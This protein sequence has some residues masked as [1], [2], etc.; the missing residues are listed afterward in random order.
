MLTNRQREIALILLS[1]E[2]NLF[3][4]EIAERFSVSLRTIK[5]DMQE[6]KKWFLKNKVDIKSKPN[7]GIVISKLDEKKKIEIY[8][9]LLSLSVDEEI[10]SIEARIRRIILML[11]LH[12]SKYMTAEFLANQLLVSEQ[13]IYKDMK[14]VKEY[15]KN[16]NIIFLSLPRKGY[17]ISGDEV[18]IRQYAEYLLTNKKIMEDSY[19]VDVYLKYKEELSSLSLD[20]EKTVQLVHQ[21]LQKTISQSLINYKPTSVELFTL[22]I[23]LVISIC[24]VLKGK[25]IQLES[26][27]NEFNASLTNFA[28]FTYFVA[29]RTFEQSDLQ[30]TKDEFIYIYRNA[31]LNNQ[32]EN[33]LEITNNI[34]HYVSEK[35]SVPFYN[36]STLKTNLYSHF[37]D[38][39]A[40]ENAILLENN[41]FM[42]DI[43]SQYNYLYYPVK[44]AC[45][46]YI[47][48]PNLSVKMIS[49]FVTLH[50]LVSLETTFSNNK[51]LKA[52]YVCASG[53]GVARVIK[54][55]VEKEVPQIRIIQFC[56][57]DDFDKVIKKRTFDLIISVFPLEI[58]IP[59]VW[60][61][62]V[63]SAENIKELKNIVSNLIGNEHCIP[64]PDM[65]T[66]IRSNDLEELS[67]E[68]ILEAMELYLALKQTFKGRIRQNMEETF[69][70]HIFLM[71]H[72]IKF[73]MDYDHLI[74]TFFIKTDDYQKVDAIF[75]KQ[76][77]K[78]SSDE[79]KAILFYIEKE[80]EK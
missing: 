51:F 35:L 48:F 26:Y 23:R 41:P 65:Y 25:I 74:N 49:S 18:N 40:E 32:Q 9:T 55:R 61:D 15:L 78:A 44:E 50:F 69:L 80:E 42:E 53:K 45:Q 46:K 58:K 68:I 5:S 29:D 12:S 79:K 75:K 28:T 59:T 3:Y 11:I 52:L 20:I 38:K 31:L 71:V 66:N 62:P 36:D 2:Q 76:G 21:K 14:K 22:F 73:S 77:I 33:L 54:N 64:S 57:L 39:F 67:R 10:W 37:L 34:I 30:I 7:K 47:Q 16:N 60:V 27:S 17:T 63:P 70:M 8:H 56:G 1:N 13:T 19:K 72:R 43:K 6:V 4:K 24:R